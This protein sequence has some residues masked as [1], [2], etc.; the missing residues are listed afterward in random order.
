MESGKRRIKESGVV[1]GKSDSG[2][3]R[4][5]PACTSVSS[6]IVSVAAGEGWGC[7]GTLSGINLRGG[8]G[9]S[10]RCRFYGWWA[11]HSDLTLWDRW[12]DAWNWWTLPWL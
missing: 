2:C 4:G 11:V 7:I 12:G 8:G 6:A 10:G 3:R 1:A 5:M 9:I